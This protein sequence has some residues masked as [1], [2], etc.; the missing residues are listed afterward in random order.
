MMRILLCLL[1]LS[2]PAA[3]DRLELL[4]DTVWTNRARTFGGLSGLYI[5]PN[6]DAV[7]AVTDRGL[8]VRAMLEREDGRITAILDTKLNPIRQ[9]NGDPVKQYTSD[10]EGLAVGPQGEIYVA[11]EGFHR[12]RR[13]DTVTGPAHHIPGHTD[14]QHLQRN[15]GLEA[16][17]VDPAGMLY[18]VPE[19]SGAWER[20]F[21]VYRLK[22][23]RWDKNLS[24][25]RS[26]K[27]LPTDAT[28]GPDSRF[29]LL[30]RDL[31]GIFGFKTRIRSFA[32]SDNGFGDERLLLETAAGTFDNLEGLSIWRDRAGEIRL[33]LVSDDNFF[34]L[35]KTRI[36]EFLL[37]SE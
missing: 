7:L 24:L 15:S 25:P 16:L 10:A 37:V 30:E 28:F 13:Y 12:V 1:W 32:L 11:F 2:V 33:T 5:S 6:G 20:P 31:A 3:A 35:L 17:A 19:Q 21:P 36:V 22:N 9:I 8:F 18:G 27:F 29:Y 34:P 26:K 23:G 4:S 14:F